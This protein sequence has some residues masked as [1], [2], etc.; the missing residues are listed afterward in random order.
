MR[1]FFEGLHE[2]G[3]FGARRIED[4]FFVICDPGVNT[5][6]T[7]CGEFQFVIGFA[8]NRDNE[9]HSFRISHSA[10]GAKV[11]PVSLN[12]LNLAQYSPAELEWVDGIAGRL[13]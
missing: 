10:L 6:E 2:S 13:S 5:L 11:Q 3:T 8:A 12:R 1:L 7:G 9:F 4:A